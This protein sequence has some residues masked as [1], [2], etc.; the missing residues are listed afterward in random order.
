MHSRP[1]SR[2]GCG[3]AQRVA[4]D[5]QASAF[6]RVL[7]LRDEIGAFG[8]LVYAGMDCAYFHDADGNCVEIIDLYKD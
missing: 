5:E 1:S 8:E 3:L 4:A 7:S 6:A 2:R